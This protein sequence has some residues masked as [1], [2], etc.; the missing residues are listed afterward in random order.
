[1]QEIFH[2]KGNKDIS[3]KNT[4]LSAFIN[5]DKEQL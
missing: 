5:S 4:Y 1:M 2:L 3:K